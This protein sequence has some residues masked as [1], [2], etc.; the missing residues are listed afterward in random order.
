MNFEI[1]CIYDVERLILYTVSLLYCVWMSCNE[2]HQS[3]TTKEN[4]QY[5]WEDLEK[6]IFPK[7]EV[8]FQIKFIA[9]IKFYKKKKYCITESEGEIYFRTY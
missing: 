7:L 3:P 6:G 2:Y 8:R 4:V 1:I 5:H 9:F